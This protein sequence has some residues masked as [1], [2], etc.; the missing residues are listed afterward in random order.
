VPSATAPDG[1]WAPVTTDVPNDNLYGA[2]FFTS[3]TSIYAFGGGFN[4]PSNKLRK[5]DVDNRKWTASTEMLSPRRF[6]TAITITIDDAGLS[7]AC[8]GF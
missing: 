4:G 2:M 1:T 8:P 6:G 5:Y 3:G 7:P